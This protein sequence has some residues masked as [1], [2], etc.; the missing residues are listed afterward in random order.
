MKFFRNIDNLYQILRC[1]IPEVSNIQYTPELSEENPE[2]AIKQT[3]PEEKLTE[4]KDATRLN[5]AYD[6]EATFSCL[7]K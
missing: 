2:R 6:D 4:E 1:H 7:G 3:W 5:A